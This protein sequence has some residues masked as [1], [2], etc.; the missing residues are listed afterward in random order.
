MTGEKQME[1]QAPERAFIKLLS[2]GELA[3][4][5]TDIRKEHRDGRPVYEYALLQQSTSERCGECE[6]CCGHDPAF[7]DEQ[8][9][10][11]FNVGGKPCDHRCGWVTIGT[12]RV[13][14]ENETETFIP[15]T[16]AEGESQK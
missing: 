4:Y 10:C 9:K 6:K 2:D 16:V 1:Q 3:A 13:D 7:K 12:I 14:V 15:A 5:R 8:R 11:W